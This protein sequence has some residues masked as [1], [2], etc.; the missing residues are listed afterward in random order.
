MKKIFIIVGVLNASALIYG[1]YDS[2]A[3][4]DHHCSKDLLL[5]TR[6]FLESKEKGNFSEMQAD[7]DDFFATLKHCRGDIPGQA[8]Q[9]A[10]QALD[11]IRGGSR[12]YGAYG[13]AIHVLATQPII[14][15][16][17]VGRYVAIKE[18]D[19]S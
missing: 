12:S 2:Q 10:S 4:I 13:Q 14:F 17:E 1:S 9:A 7:A 8:R 11:L 16:I 6:S 19:K 15:S 3:L 5:R 18:S